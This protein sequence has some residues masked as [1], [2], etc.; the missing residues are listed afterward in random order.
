MELLTM[1]MRE[2]LGTLASVAAQLNAASDEVNAIVEDF[3]E[4]LEAAGVG[5]T[6]WL[7]PLLESSVPE[8]HYDHERE[9]EWVSAKGIQLGYAKVDGKWRA[10][11]RDVTIMHDGGNRELR[12]ARTP[13]PLANSPRPI[14]IEAVARLENLAEALTE[15]MKGQLGAIEKGKKLAKS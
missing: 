13:T 9:I 4:E 2:T 7:L 15:K 12:D 1:P 10:A 5:T 8:T 6:L 11:V 3:E 14:R